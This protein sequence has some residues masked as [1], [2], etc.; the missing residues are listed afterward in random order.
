MHSNTIT[1]DQLR[2][3]ACSNHAGPHHACIACGAVDKSIVMHNKC[4]Q[5]SAE[6]MRAV[7]APCVPKRVLHT[8]FRADVQMQQHQHQ[9][10]E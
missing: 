6:V 5:H 2:R 10:D 9:E 4:C 3:E 7:G 1:R 8:R